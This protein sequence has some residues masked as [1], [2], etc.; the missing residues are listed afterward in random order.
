MLHRAHTC[1]HQ[2]YGIKAYGTS[3]LFA[4]LPCRAMGTAIT[5]ELASWMIRPSSF[6]RILNA[7]VSRG[8]GQS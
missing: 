3:L 7:L 6:L 4:P 5:F 8:D 1:A 2:D